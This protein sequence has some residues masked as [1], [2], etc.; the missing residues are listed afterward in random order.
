MKKERKN[1]AISILGDSISTFEGYNPNGYAVFYD[2]QMQQITGLTS[3]DDTWWGRVIRTMK[4]SLCV[5]DSYSGSLVTG[6]GFPAASSVER[7]S[8]LEKKDTKPDIILLYIGFNDFGN[9][10]RISPDPMGDNDYHCFEPAY[11]GML[12]RL[13]HN[14]PKAT[15]VCG[16]LMRT[17]IESNHSFSFPETYTGVPYEEYNEAI[18]RIALKN[19]CILADLAKSDVRYETLDG[20]HP[21]AKGHT[22]IADEWIARL[23]ELGIQG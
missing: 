6:N 7:T 14:Y 4:A 21:T 8:N 9:G 2:K 19:Q 5:N 10:I 17:K 22:T 1:V 23:T 15:I 18:R 11:D 12:K 16:S 3:V 20:T 13:K